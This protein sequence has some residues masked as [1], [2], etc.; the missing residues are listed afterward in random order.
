MHIAVI[1]PA[2]GSS[3][4]YNESAHEAGMDAGVE[5]QKIDED[6]G[7]RPMLQ[8]TVELFNKHPDV[9]AVIV[10]GPADPHAFAAFKDRHADKLALL[11]ATICQGG[12]DHRYETVANALKLVPES[13]TH[14]AVHDAARPCAS[15]ELI[16]RVFEAAQAGHNA[17]VPAID[18]PDTL[19]RVSADTVAAKKPDPL[20][21]ILGEDSSAKSKARLVEQTIDRTR[22]VAV[23]TPQLFERTLLLKAYAQKDL[24]STDDAQL[25]EKLGEKV[26]TVQGDSTN[27]KVT[28]AQDLTLARAILNVKPPAQ[29]EAHK[30]F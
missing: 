8:R 4:R 7:G 2:A 1:I 28:R 13:C 9:A 5:K 30:R 20:A 11:G 24:S 26:V 21:A 15:P 17:V 6:L 18:V 3:R 29:R 12:K 19:K 16:E 25:I 27:I 14:V 10:A 23:Q 22:I